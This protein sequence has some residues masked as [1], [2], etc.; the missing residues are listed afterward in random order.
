MAS[1]LDHDLVVIQRHQPLPQ[2]IYF[3]HSDSTFNSHVTIKYLTFNLNL[4]EVISKKT[5]LKVE[6]LT[7]NRTLFNKVYHRALLYQG[8]LEKTRNFARSLM[9]TY[10]I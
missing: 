1:C 8:D 9:Q 5:M 10:S 2:P 7:V 3:I 4:E 6:Y